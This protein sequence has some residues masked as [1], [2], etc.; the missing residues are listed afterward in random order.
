MSWYTQHPTPTATTTARMA[1]R[2]LYRLI[3]SMRASYSK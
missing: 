1:A 2:T 3:S